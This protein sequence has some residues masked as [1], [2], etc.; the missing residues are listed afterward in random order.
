ML[1]SNLQ[2]NAYYGELL[3]V[4]NRKRQNL[5]YNADFLILQRYFTIFVVKS[6]I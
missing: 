2:Y 5:H 1:L 6:A 4:Y 3:L